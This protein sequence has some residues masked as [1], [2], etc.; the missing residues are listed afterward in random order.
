VVKLW[1]RAACVLA[2]AAG[3]VAGASDAARRP[4][5]VGRRTVMLGRSVDG[6]AIV[7]VERGDFDSR[8]KV[9]VVGCIH[10][11][12]CA[13]LA[14]T[15]RLIR[16]R[17]PREIDLWILSNLNPDGA[18]AGARGNAHRVDLNRNFPWRWQRV[19]GVFYSGSG[20]LSEPESRMASR[21]IRRLRPGIS[22]WFHE[23]LDV[24]D[25]SGGSVAVERR[26]AALVGLR[27]VRLQ[28]E[29]GSVV[30]WENHELRSGTAFVVELP[31]GG[32]NRAAAAR[33]AD[34]IVT[35][36]GDRTLV[37][38]TDVRSKAS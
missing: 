29:P 22:I 25:E 30:G 32:L 31:A 18:A 3:L 13:G 2:L 1:L 24:V 6:R 27:L 35:L 34:A 26:F 7:A 19:G 33:F 11:N 17:P 21:L 4:T 8:R 20:P 28:R 5:D 37:H 9:L 16:M 23:H 36:A 10:G 14:V 12:E 38:A 15:A